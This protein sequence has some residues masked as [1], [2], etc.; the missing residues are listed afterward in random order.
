M[1][2]GCVL[3][4]THVQANDFKK[5]FE[6][7]RTYQQVSF[8]STRSEQQKAYDE[9]RRQQNAQYVAQLRENWQEYPLSDVLQPIEKNSIMPTDYRQTIVTSTAGE[10]EENTPLITNTSILYLPE[11]TPQPQPMVPIQPK[12]QE[13]EVVSIALYGTL[14]S[15]AFPK[16]ADLHLRGVDEYNISKLWEQIADTI[17]PNKF[18]NTLASCLSKRRHMNLCDW[19]YLQMVKAI[20]NRRYGNSNEATIFAAY[21]MAQSGYKIRLAY[22]DT[23]IYLLIA[24][25][26]EIY[27]MSR[28]KVENEWY[29]MVDGYGISSCFISNAGL[30]EEHKL[31][32]FIFDELKIDAEP[33]DIVYAT[34]SQGWSL[35][36][37]VN[38][39]LIDFYD[40]Y[41]AC[42]VFNGDESSKWLIAVNTPLDAVAKQTLYPHILDSIRHLTPWAATAMILNWV[43]TAF[44]Y[45]LDNNVWGNDRVFF[46]EETLYY[47]R[48][49]CE[50]RA[51]LFTTLVRDILGLDVL[52]LCY[53][54]PYHVATAVH[55]PVEEAY[56]KYVMHDGKRYM[57]CD[58]TFAN[59]SIGQEMPEYKYSQAQIIVP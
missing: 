53:E 4:S 43:Q 59:A 3:L 18:D 55:F 5:R 14:I 17:V 8:D 19:A 56:G 23:R 33:S 37:Q 9:F 36:I 32:L 13:E 31:S 35:P 28:Y 39:N 47:P 12:P 40:G 25:Q 1:L 10:I 22:T 2:I 15:I 26:H 20:S 38:T 21:L 27:G 42:R 49:D 48:S 44:R 11:K 50:D 6:E 51:I 30:R 29:Y 58:P 54:N 52:L 45:E 41:P 7:F 57:V 16:D 46:S 34:S 24:S